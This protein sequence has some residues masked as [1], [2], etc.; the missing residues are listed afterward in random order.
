MG[1]TGDR[2]F[3]RDGKIPVMAFDIVVDDGDGGSGGGD[4]GAEL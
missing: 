4:N 3:D 1:I 2:S